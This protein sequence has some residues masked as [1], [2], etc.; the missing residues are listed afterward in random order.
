MTKAINEEEDDVKI[1]E[2]WKIVVISVT[3]I[4]LLFSIYTLAIYT[5][6]SDFKPPKEVGAFGDMYGGIN[7]L[8]SGLAFGGIILTIYLQRNEL[9]L[10]RKEL[11]LTRNE[12]KQQNETL[13]NQSFENTFFKM[14]SL[15]HEIV[16]KLEIEEMPLFENVET[17]RYEKRRVFDYCKDK[18]SRLLFQRK[19]GD[20]L[21]GKSTSREIAEFNDNY[22]ERPYKEFFNSTTQHLLS[23]YFRNLYHIF[24]YIYSS[25]MEKESQ[26]FYASL[27]R[28]QL[29]SHELYLLFY[30]GLSHGYGNPNFLFYMKEFDLL[31]NFDA[32]LVSS[33]HIIVYNHL[34]KN[35]TLNNE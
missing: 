25:N 28:A 2:T 33:Q 16:D 8:F 20:K 6:Y 18:L 29:S 10:Q 30:N 11:R 4:I 34:I 35:V 22:I 15:H 24:K 19:K 7:A 14:I 31:D 5:S 12:F 3:L 26:Q 23:H 17:E 13:K 9:T 32:S 27:A 21:H 1:I